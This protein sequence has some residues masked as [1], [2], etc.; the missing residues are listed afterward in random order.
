MLFSSQTHFSKALVYLMHFC[1]LFY[2]FACTPS[3][4]VWIFKKH[5]TWQGCL[6][7]L[8]DTAGSSHLSYGL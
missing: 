3:P 5:I 1:A 2:E 8:Q 7:L 4:S 6:N